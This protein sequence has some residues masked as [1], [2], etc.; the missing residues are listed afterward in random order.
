[1]ILASFEEM[2]GQAKHLGPVRAAVAAAGHP[3]VLKGVAMAQQEGIIKALLVDDEEKIRR[4]AEELGLS[5]EGMAILN[6]PE[7]KRASFD[8]VSLAAQGRTDVI[9]KG[10]LKTDELLGAALRH[11]GGIRERRLLTHV[12]L[13][14]IPR[15]DRLIYLSDSG[16][17]VRP[18]IYQKV[19]I[20]QNVVNVAH[21]FGVERPKVAVLSATEDID[22]SLP[23]SIESLALSRMAREGWVEGAV[24]DGPMSLDVA[25]SSHAARVKEV[26][27]PVAGRADILIV[28][29]VISGNIM[30]KSILYFGT[31]RMAGLVV[32]ARVPI[33][34]SSRS[35]SAETRFLSLAMAG[36]IS[37]FQRQLML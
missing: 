3:E 24:V 32:G 29:D 4:L 30:A 2:V 11:E 35:D 10:N 36:I 8:V 27:G 33:L 34:I 20:I 14:E 26:A 25:I 15:L 23:I 5:L 18:D 6:E 37:H 19:E 21:S 13:F 9:V 7:P 22:P 12:G 17:V 28:P 16:V 1:M 31:G